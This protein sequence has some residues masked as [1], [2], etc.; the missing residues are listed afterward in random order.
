MIWSISRD[1]VSSAHLPAHPPSHGP[2]THK[3]KQ[4]T[5]TSCVGACGRAALWTSSAQ[6]RHHDREGTKLELRNFMRP[7]LTSFSPPLCSV[8]T[9][10]R[11]PPPLAEPP[12]RELGG[13]G[14]GGGVVSRPSS[15]YVSLL[16]P[17]LPATFGTHVGRS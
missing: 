7:S 2:V 4:L 3:K 6:R 14:G 16:Q 17:C 13:R 11:R 12:S 9:F 10:S 15:L 5:V 1:T 8:V